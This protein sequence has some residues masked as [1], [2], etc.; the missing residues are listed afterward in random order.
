MQTPRLA[1]GAFVIPG[2]ALRGAPERPRY[3]GRDELQ[4][5]VDRAQHILELMAALDDEPGRRDDAVGALLARETRILLDPVERNLG[6][7]PENRKHRAVLEEV[8]RV[9]TPLAG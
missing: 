5:F 2:S 9:I 3:S 4:R 1:P 6:R 8:D 7:A